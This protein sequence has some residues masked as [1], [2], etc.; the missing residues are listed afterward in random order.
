MPFQSEKQRR[1]LFK[2][3]PEVARKFA[4]HSDRSVPL[5]KGGTTR[6]V[7][8]QS[9]RHIPEDEKTKRRLRP[10][11]KKRYGR[12]VGKIKTGQGKGLNPHRVPMK[13]E[14]GQGQLN[15]RQMA[16]LKRMKRKK[17]A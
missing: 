6:P 12:P 8:N 14:K 4:D 17:R 7:S 16:I 5:Y 13:I 10:V 3:R 15:E 2:E 9:D 1:Y 11:A